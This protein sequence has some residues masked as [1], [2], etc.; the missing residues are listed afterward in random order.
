MTTVDGIHMASQSITLR[1]VV[2]SYAFTIR[3]FAVASIIDTIIYFHQAVWE[4][5]DKRLYV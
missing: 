3:Q 5:K 2:Y 4:I 1:I